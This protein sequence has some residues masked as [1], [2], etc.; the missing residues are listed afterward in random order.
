MNN[1]EH[2][3][4]P[5]HGASKLLENSVNFFRAS[6]QLQLI[7]LLIFA[8]S[9]ALDAT[10]F[11]DLDTRVRLA[12]GGVMLLGTI[13]S[14]LQAFDN[15]RRYNKVKSILREHGW[16]ERVMKPMEHW[17]C[18]RYA[19]RKAAIDTGHKEEVDQYYRRTGQSWLNI[20]EK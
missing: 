17:W 19:A 8:P 15:L 2:R 7:N 18:D 13:A 14:E 3:N 12:L 1:P 6:P 5:Q 16:D 20:Y 9:A 10:Y 11:S 4:A